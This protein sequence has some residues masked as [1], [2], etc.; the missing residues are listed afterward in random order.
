[1]SILQFNYSRE[2]TIER[3]SGVSVSETMAARVAVNRRTKRE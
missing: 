3:L 2:H 1:M